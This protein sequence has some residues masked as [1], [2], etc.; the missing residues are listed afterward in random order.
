MSEVKFFHVKI[1]SFL[2]LFSNNFKEIIM[3]MLYKSSGYLIS[4]NILYI[5]ALFCNTCVFEPEMWMVSEGIVCSSDDERA[6]FR[7]TKH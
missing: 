1:S 4:E 2:R 6:E 3:L 7:F 5:C